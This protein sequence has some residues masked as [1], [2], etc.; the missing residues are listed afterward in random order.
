MIA[1]ITLLLATLFQAAEKPVG[2][3]HEM[4]GE[5]QL[6][7]K[8]G[9]SLPLSPKRLYLFRG[10]RLK[11]AEGAHITIGF[12]HDLHWEKVTEGEVSITATQC[13]PSKHVERLPMP[14]HLKTPIA[15]AGVKMLESGRGAA[16]TLRAAGG[17]SH[18]LPQI[19][20]IFEEAIDTDRPNFQWPSVTDAKVYQLT[21]SK[22]DSPMW[23]Y[24]TETASFN[25][26]ADKE[27]LVR[28]RTYQ[29]TVV[30][31]NAEERAVAKFEG[32]FSVMSLKTVED[33]QSIDK[34][35]VST[36]LAERHIALA[37]YQRLS[38]FS[39]A[40]RTCEEVAGDAASPE[41]YRVLEELYLRAG[42]QSDSQKAA[43]QAR[44]NSQPTLRNP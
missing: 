41:L 34:L 25:F 17:S 9:Q 15:S 16:V 4:S 10:D 23:S 33:L 18:A 26:P 6:I 24:E 32:R 7:A 42:R 1:T 8:S 36:T 29:W 43:K 39:R 30:A 31:R 20:P 19:S 27:A 40:I 13:E 22:G 5:I 37:A 35:A 3:I 2:L 38:A 14:A 11:L 28:N 44:E 21:V 12:F